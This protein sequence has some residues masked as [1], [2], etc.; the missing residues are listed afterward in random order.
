SFRDG[1]QPDDLRTVI[2]GP[3]ADF[4]VRYDAENPDSAYG[5]VVSVP[6]F[7]ASSGDR[8]EGVPASWD[9]LWVNVWG[10]PAESESGQAAV[11]TYGQEMMAAFDKVTECTDDQMYD[12]RVVGLGTE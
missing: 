4:L 5:T 12:G 8:H 7:D 10:D 11:D 9:L 3:W 1:M 6:D 2:R